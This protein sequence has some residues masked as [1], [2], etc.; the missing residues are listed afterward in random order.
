M[1]KL[2]ICVCP[3][4]NTPICLYLYLSFNSIFS[5]LKEKLKGKPHKFYFTFLIKKIFELR[6]SSKRTKL[7]ESN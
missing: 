7:N 3:L 4:N 5:F 2:C 6:D 1:Y